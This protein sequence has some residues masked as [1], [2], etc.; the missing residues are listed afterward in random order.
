MYLGPLSY[1][2]V[3]HQPSQV[4]PYTAHHSF[5]SSSDTEETHINATA[6]FS[7]C[8]ILEASRTTL[9]IWTPGLL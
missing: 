3:I 7:F 2:A 9:D 4:G 1:C 6:T 5:A 8:Q